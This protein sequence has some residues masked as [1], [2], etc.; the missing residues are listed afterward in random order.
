MC[1]VFFVTGLA[2]FEAHQRR[3]NSPYHLTRDSVPPSM[4]NLFPDNSTSLSSSPNLSIST[5]NRLFLSGF[6]QNIESD[7]TSRKRTTEDFLPEATSTCER[8]KQQHQIPPS[9][10]EFLW[11]K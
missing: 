10:Q 11:Q 3:K 4:R 7:V 6:A 5:T 9:E 2:K 8:V 1:Y